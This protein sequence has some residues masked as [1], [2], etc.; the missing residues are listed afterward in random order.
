MGASWADEYPVADQQEIRAFLQWRAVENV[1]REL[2][3][4][5]LSEFF[6]PNGQGL[7]CQTMFGG[8]FMMPSLSSGDT[9]G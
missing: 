6:G 1:L 7:R 4:E 9:T 3:I 8:N 2:I 5:Q